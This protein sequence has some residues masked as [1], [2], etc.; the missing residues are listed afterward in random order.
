MFAAELDKPQR[1]LKLRYADQVNP[2]E[3]IRCVEHVTTLVAEIEPGFRVLTDLTNLGSMDA[4]CAPHIAAMMDLLREHGVEVAIRIGPD[5]HKDIG[6]NI[7]SF[8][9]YGSKVRTETYETLAD[10]ISSLAA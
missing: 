6:L 3:M 1:L 2:E 9:H 10:A 7:L 8:F 5:P 4:A